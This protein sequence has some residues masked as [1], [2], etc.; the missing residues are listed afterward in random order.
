MI[1][2]HR[3]AVT[4]FQRIGDQGVADRHFAHA[5]HGA[6]EAREVVAVQ[7]MAGVHAQP[8]V[9]R[10]ARCR[11]VALQLERLLCR[12]PSLGVGFGIELDAVRADGARCGHRLRIGIHEQAH[13]HARRLG[14][15]NQGAQAVG[16]LRKAPTVVAG[17]L[18]FAVGHKGRLLRAQVAHKVHQVVQRVALDVELASRPVLEQRGQFM[19]VTGTDVALVRPRMHGDALSPRLQTQPGRARHAGNAQVPG[20]AHQGHLVQVYGERCTLSHRL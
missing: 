2:L 10:R 6:Q 15:G 18:A 1:V 3:G 17:E 9:L 16:I 13:A 8:Q 5:G 11:R 14:L 4:Q 19:H 20:V 12:A 7:V